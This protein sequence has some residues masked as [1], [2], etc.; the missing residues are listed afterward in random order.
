MNILSLV[1]IGAIIFSLLLPVLNANQRNKSSIILIPV[2]SKHG[3][4][5]SQHANVVS[6]SKSSK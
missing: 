3:N 6:Q 1:V 2:A 5:I 4:V